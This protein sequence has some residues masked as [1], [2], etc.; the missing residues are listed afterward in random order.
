M[1]SD[2][3]FRER[4]RMLMRGDS[5]MFP[6]KEYCCDCGEPTGK[7]G[8]GDGSLYVYE[9]GSGPYCDE[10]FPGSDEDETPCE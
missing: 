1:S 3:A 4:D 2:R 5:D 6:P 10:C 8:R 9:D 7:A